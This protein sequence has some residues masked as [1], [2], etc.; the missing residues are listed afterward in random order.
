MDE[1]IERI[2]ELTDLNTQLKANNA[3]LEKQVADLLALEGKEK[4]LRDAL[5]AE[6][7]L[8][9]KFKREL[10]EMQEQYSER[11]KDLERISLA[12]ATVSPAAIESLGK[13]VTA[14]QNAAASIQTAAECV[15]DHA[16]KYFFFYCFLVACAIGIGGVSLFNLSRLGDRVSNIAKNLNDILYLLMNQ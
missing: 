7:R 9:E 1:L 6:K 10:E 15:K 8:N 12:A 5:E 3:E 16:W 2:E 14:L 4:E 11:L 13:N